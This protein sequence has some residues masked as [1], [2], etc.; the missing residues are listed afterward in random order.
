VDYN[1]HQFTGNEDN[2]KF[3]FPGDT[4]TISLMRSR[5]K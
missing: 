2:S 4:Q 5:W 3:I 1:K